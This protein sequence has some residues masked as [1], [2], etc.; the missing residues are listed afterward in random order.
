MAQ[1][2]TCEL[3]N[4]KLSLRNSDT[5]WNHSA[6]CSLPPQG[7]HI[8]SVR[9][10]FLPASDFRRQVSAPHGRARLTEALCPQSLESLETPRCRHQGLQRGC[11]MEAAGLLLALL[12]K[13]SFHWEDTTVGAVFFLKR[14]KPWGRC[15]RM[16]RD[17]TTQG[18]V[19]AGSFDNTTEPTKFFHSYYVAIT[20]LPL[21]HPPPISLSICLFSPQRVTGRCRPLESGS[22]PGF[23]PQRSFSVLPYFFWRPSW[24]VSR[25]RPLFV[26][27][28]ISGCDLA[29]A[30]DSYGCYLGLKQ[31]E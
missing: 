1:P 27:H 4:R 19:I 18:Q 12:C 16:L 31:Y 28:S 8:K 13:D 9:P 20:F 11:R 5:S 17:K 2:V 25:V 29:L 3:R 15:N 22:D 24:F 7:L 21:C 30:K 26:F 6:S 14:L 23:F 10:A